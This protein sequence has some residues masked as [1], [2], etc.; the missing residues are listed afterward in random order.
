MAIQNILKKG[1][2]AEKA[3]RS[4]TSDRGHHEFD[5][6]VSVKRSNISAL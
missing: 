6:D 2:K 1:H 5:I 3:T 4:L